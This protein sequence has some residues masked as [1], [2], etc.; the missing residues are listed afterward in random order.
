MSSFNDHAPVPNGSLESDRFGHRR[1]NIERG[2]HEHII[3]CSV[4][5]RCGRISL[6]VCGGLQQS[7]YSALCS[8]FEPRSERSVR[9]T[10]RCLC[11]S[12]ILCDRFSDGCDCCWSHRKCR[13]RAI[14]TVLSHRH[15]CQSQR[16]D[17]HS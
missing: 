14:L 17:V 16:N 8:R 15:R 7:S 3:K 9:Q 5:R 13:R 11:L 4:P 10:L 2:I 6:L 12:S 1:S